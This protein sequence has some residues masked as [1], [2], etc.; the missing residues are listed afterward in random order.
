MPPAGNKVFSLFLLQSI[1]TVTDEA[2]DRA[3][4]IAN[5]ALIIWHSKGRSAKARPR[6]KKF[7]EYYVQ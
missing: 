4:K 7:V 5:R 3:L 1:Q 2:E 6:N